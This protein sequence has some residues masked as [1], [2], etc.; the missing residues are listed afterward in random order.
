MGCLGG[1]FLISGGLCRHATSGAGQSLGGLL[2]QSKHFSIISFSFELKEVSNFLCFW[3]FEGNSWLCVFHDSGTRNVRNSALLQPVS[4]QAV[5]RLCFLSHSMNAKM[6]CGQLH[7]GSSEVWFWMKNG[8][9]IPGP[10]RM[11]EVCFIE[12]GFKKFHGFSKSQI[13]FWGLS[14]SRE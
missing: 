3:L 4:L 6:V 1:Y 11:V 9:P 12:I 10:P 2:L 14:R 13:F 8:E 5:E 7:C